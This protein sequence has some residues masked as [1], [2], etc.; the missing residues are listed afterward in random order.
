MLHTS[1]S[2]IMLRIIAYDINTVNHCTKIVKNNAISYLHTY[3]SRQYYMG[4][5][6]TK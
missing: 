6:L 1:F 5:K 3:L 2:F 4:I